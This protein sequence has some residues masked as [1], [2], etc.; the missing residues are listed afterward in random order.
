MTGFSLHKNVAILLSFL[1]TLFKTKP[2]ENR[3]MREHGNHD[4]NLRQAELKLSLRSKC[5]EI[6][7]KEQI[8][9]KKFAD[10]HDKQIECSLL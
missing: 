10:L 5:N 9:Q 8:I 1:I 6:Y 4:L 7:N 3:R 2:K